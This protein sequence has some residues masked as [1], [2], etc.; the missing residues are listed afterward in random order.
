M[1]NNDLVRVT[2]GMQ[3]NQF[4]LDFYGSDQAQV[5]AGNGLLCIGPGS[6]ILHR[7]PVEQSDGAGTLSHEVDLTTRPVI[8]AG[9]TWNFQL[10]YREPNGGGAEY[11]F[12][13]A[14]SVLFCD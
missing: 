9:S 1:S 10:W 6:T 12:S 2:S 13:D 14:L 4:G 3:A 5:P 11:N 8:T 7:L